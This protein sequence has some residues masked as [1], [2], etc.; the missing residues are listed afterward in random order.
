MPEVIRSQAH[1]GARSAGNSEVFAVDLDY[2]L[3]SRNR[4]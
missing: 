3:R 2:L 1:A 4:G